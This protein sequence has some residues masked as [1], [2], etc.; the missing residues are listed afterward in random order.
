MNTNKLTE[1]FTQDVENET[2]KKALG[3]FAQSGIFGKDFMPEEPAYMRF[4]K[5]IELAFKAGWQ[6]RGEEQRANYGGE[7][8]NINK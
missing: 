3:E 1:L 6:L 5:M 2:Y 7:I 8:E 4:G